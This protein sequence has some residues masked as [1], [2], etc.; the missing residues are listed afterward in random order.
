[1]PAKHMFRTADLTCSNKLNSLIA[2]NKCTVLM[3][4]H[5]E[6]GSEHTSIKFKASESG[7]DYQ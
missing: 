4:L 6:Q 1:V 7:D 3:I 5:A 2:A